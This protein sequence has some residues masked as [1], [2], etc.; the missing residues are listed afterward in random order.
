MKKTTYLNVIFI[1]SIVML[2]IWLVLELV[3]DYTGSMWASQTRGYRDYLLYVA[4]VLN[5]AIILIRRRLRI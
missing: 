3:D 5:I 2:A 4:A 1:A